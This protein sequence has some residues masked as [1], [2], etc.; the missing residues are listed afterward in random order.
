M[1]FWRNLSG[2]APLRKTGCGFSIGADSDSFAQFRNRYAVRAQT[3]KPSL[4]RAGLAGGC[5]SLT[6]TY[7]HTG[8]RTII[9]AEAFHCPVRDGKEWDH[10]AMVIRLNWSPGCCLEQPSQFM[11]IRIDIMTACSRKGKP[12]VFDGLMSIHRQSYRVKPHGQLVSV[13]LTHYCASTPDLS[14]SWS[15]TTLQGAQ[16]PGKTH[17]ETSFQL[18]CFQRL[19]LPHIAT[20][21]CHWRDNR[22][23]RGASTPVL[24]Y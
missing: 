9:G 8:T 17:L 24:S 11:E 21:Q 10:L 19:S 1:R 3:K 22:Y 12:R 18:R 16:G 2:R 4:V 15:R 6:M 13:S 5:K 7:F 23:T 14:T 20:R